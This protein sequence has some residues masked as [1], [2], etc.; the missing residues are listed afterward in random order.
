MSLE[1]RVA[2]PQCVTAAIVEAAG[3]GTPG[4]HE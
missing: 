1:L 3:V 2:R 4:I